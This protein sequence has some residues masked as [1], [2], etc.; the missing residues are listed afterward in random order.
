MG[1]ATVDYACS[2][3]YSYKSL[4]FDFFSQIKVSFFVYLRFWVTPGIVAHSGG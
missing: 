1:K 4:N 3:G 2:E